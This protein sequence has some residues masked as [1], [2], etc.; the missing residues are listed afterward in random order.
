MSVWGPGYWWMELD[1]DGE[2]TGHICSA[3]YGESDRPMQGTWI[4]VGQIMV[5]NGIVVK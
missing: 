1:E 2:P 4:L 3:Y 5:V